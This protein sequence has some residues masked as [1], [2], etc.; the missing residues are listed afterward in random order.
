MTHLPSLRQLRHLV[1]LAD[2]LHFGR[3]ARACHVTQSTL[4]VSIMALEE[5]LGANLV[6]RHQKKVLLTPLGEEVAPRARRLLRDAEELT[7]L[8]RARA[9]PFTGLLKLGVIPTIGP[10]LLPRVLPRL[11]RKF[12]GL[13][14]YLREDLTRRLLEMLERGELDVAIIALPYATPGI[15]TAPMFE[16]EFV[17]A[18]RADEMPRAKRAKRSEI[19]KHPLLLLAEGHCLREHALEACQLPRTGLAAAVE[20][21]SLYTL[22]QMVEAGLGVTL[23]PKLAVAAGILRGTKLSV[24]TLEAPAQTRTVGLAWRKGT[25]RAAEFRALATAIAEAHHAGGAARKR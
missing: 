19:I 8:A 5:L 9:A 12:P 24:Y 4:S 22:V 21:T 15:E 25:R 23:L 3:A 11:R 16:D 17:L 10:F 1:A 7:E 14:P 20:G 18:A 13:T 6:D 2:S